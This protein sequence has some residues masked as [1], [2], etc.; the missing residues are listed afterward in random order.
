MASKAF[1]PGNQLIMADGGT[2]FLDEIGDMPLNLQCRLLRV[3]SER[4]VLPLG[5]DKPLKV[6]VRVICATHRDLLG[7]VRSGLNRCRSHGADRMFQARYY[8]DFA[9]TERAWPLQM[10][11]V[12]S[13]A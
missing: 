4:E 7:M 11:K 12:Q 6:D 2:L 3:L 9:P 1:R 13:R 8:K 5:A 10:S